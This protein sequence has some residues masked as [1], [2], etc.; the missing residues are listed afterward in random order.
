MF[1]IVVSTCS[2]VSLR[3]GYKWYR[4]SY[5]LRSRAHV[6]VLLDFSSQAANT[7]RKIIQ[8]YKPTISLIITFKCNKRSGTHKQHYT[9]QHTARFNLYAHT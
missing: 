8:R 7:K 4:I 9:Q 3:C 6:S 1:Y 2:F 5:G